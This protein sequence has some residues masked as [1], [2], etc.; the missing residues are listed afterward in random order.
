MFEHGVQ[1][2]ERKNW[3]RQKRSRGFTLMEVL[4]AIVILSVG[5]M[6]L[7]AVVPFAT[8]NDYRSRVDTTATFVAL[9][10]LEQILAQPSGV[11]SFI[12]AADST[13]AVTNVGGAPPGVYP[14]D[15]VTNDA[16]GT[17]APLLNGNIDFT[18]APGL[19][20]PGYARIYTVAPTP[21]NP[22]GNVR[23]NIGRYDVRWNIY[24]NV[25]GIK[26]VIV[27]A[28]RFPLPAGANFL[29]ANV[30]AVRMR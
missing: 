19:I 25:N 2:V 5:V 14:I 16:F 11:T 6:G 22:N 12:D 13:G 9:W 24:Q 30:R 28:Q 17:G 21:V 23:V 4:F 10:Q 18:V 1:S 8:E 20:L 26:T 27:A 15:A 3:S 7:A 29:P